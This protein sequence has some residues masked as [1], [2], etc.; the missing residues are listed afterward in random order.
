MN[1]GEEF[2]FPYPFIRTTYESWDG[3]GMS[4]SPS[5]APGTKQEQCAPDDFDTVADAMGFQVVKII[6]THRPS[7]QYPERV[8]YVRTFIN[9]DGVTFGDKKLRIKT[10]SAFQ[11]LIKGYCYPYRLCN[12]V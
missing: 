7:K 5:W 9:P 3:E 11:R 2:K 4:I 1:E 6:S 10:V 8:F 12:S